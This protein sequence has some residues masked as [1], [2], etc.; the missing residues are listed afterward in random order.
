MH[1][2]NSVFELAVVEAVRDQ[3]TSVSHSFSDKQELILSSI[4]AMFEDCLVGLVLVQHPQFGEHYPH[5]GVE[6]VEGADERHQ[7][8]V[9]GVA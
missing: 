1:H 8:Y 2:G 6:P 7:E 3:E 4:D 9:G 5:E